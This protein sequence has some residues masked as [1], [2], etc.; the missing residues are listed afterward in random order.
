MWWLKAATGLL[1]I[2]Y[3][4][5]DRKRAVFV[6]G[7][8]KT[9]FRA[10]RIV[11]YVFCTKIRW[12]VDIDTQVEFQVGHCSVLAPLCFKCDI[13]LFLSSKKK[14]KSSYMLLNNPHNPYYFSFPPPLALAT[15]VEVWNL[16]IQITDKDLKVL[17]QNKVRFQKDWIKHVFF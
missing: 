7:E 10:L 4:K 15:F 14:K 3:C 6:L 11:A 16:H 1:Y 8:V 13:V 12:C 9:K 17:F 5:D 2:N